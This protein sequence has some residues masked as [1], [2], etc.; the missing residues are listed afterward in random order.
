MTAKQ[1]K[2]HLRV[3]R[4][5]YAVTIRQPQAAAVLARPG[6][7]EHRGWETD[8]RGPLLIHAAR[9]AAGDPPVGRSDGPAYGALLGVVEL[10]DCIVNG[11]AGG[12][13]DEVGYVW[14]L[15]NPRTFTSPVPYGGRMGLFLVADA[16]VA[17]VLAG[18]AP[19]RPLP[20]AFK[21]VHHEGRRATPPANPP[22]D[23][24]AL[25]T[26]NGDGSGGGHGES[27]AHGAPSRLRG[28][29]TRGSR[30]PLSR[31]G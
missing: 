6:P 8:Y 7:F 1:P 28:G 29:L 5:M 19:P 10:V 14:V 15:A 25:T 31:E 21:T 11:R 13:P 9:W 2:E 3:G 4:G 30:V 12:D 23:R 26:G 27:H 17:G 16:V 18:L 22:A 24:P 20:A